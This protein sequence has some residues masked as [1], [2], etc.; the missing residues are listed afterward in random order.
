MKKKIKE[1]LSYKHKRDI[2][3]SDYL[4]DMM[5]NPQ[6][7]LKLSTDIILDAI[8]SYGWKIKMR[9]GQPVISYNV[10]KDPFSR[11]LNAIHGQ[12]NCIKSVID[13]IYSIN[14]ETGPNRG[15]VL[16]GPP[17]SGKTNIC[18][19]LTK[20]V[21]EYVKNGNIKLYTK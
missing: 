12:E 16:V 17:A 21:E 13:I 3:F 7:H 15:I 11:G 5:K 1:L 9:N 14:K 19:L 4:E 18:D 8:K 20:A 2:S 10:F 6:P